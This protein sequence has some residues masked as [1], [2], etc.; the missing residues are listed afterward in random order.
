MTLNAAEEESIEA[1]KKW[2]DENGKQLIAAVIVGFGGY[3]GWSLWQN[4]ELVASQMASDLYEEILEISVVEAGDSTTEQERSDIVRIANELMEFHSE[5]VY[6]QYGALFASQQHVINNNLDAAEA[7]LDWIL[8]NP[9]SSMF[10]SEDQ[11]LILKVTLRLARVVLSKKIGQLVASLQNW[12]STR[13][14]QDSL[15]WVVRGAG[16]VACHQDNPYQDW[17]TPGKVITAWIPLEDTSKEGATLEYLIG[18]HKN[19]TTKRLNK[20]F[21]NQSYRSISKKLLS[22]ADKF[23]RH[24][25]VAKKGSVVFHHGDMWHGS[26]FNKTKQDRITLS[27]HFMNGNSKFHNRIKNPHFNHYKILNSSKMDETFF[28]VTWHK[29]KKV[30]FKDKYLR[31]N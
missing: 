24:Y 22:N 10:G 7:A 1:I 3:G 6:A 28:P 18:S 31:R 14:N 29:S 30:F 5:S 16:S 8:E 12:N 11:G 4:T 23:G 25:V 21:T 20:F 15:I 9:Q 17:H 2:W 19:G 26:G 27:I 13:L